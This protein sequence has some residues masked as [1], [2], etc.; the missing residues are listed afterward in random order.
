MQL[1]S[2]ACLSVAAKM[3]ETN[4]PLLLDLQISNPAFVFDP[5]T[6]GRMELLLMSALRWR[7]RAV[8]PFDFISYF[9]SA[10]I[11][12]DRR[13]SV[14]PPPFSR[15]ADLI[16]STYRGKNPNLIYAN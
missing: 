10:T 14:L 11:S 1:L 2:V 13:S 6:V 16:L 12:A 8:T 7:M 4:A 5:R 3:E 9:A 15:S